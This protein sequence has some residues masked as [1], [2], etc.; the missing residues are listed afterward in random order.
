M[1]PPQAAPRSASACKQVLLAGTRIAMAFGLLCVFPLAYQMIARTGGHMSGQMAVTEIA[2]L[3][4]LS[5]VALL[6][7]TTIAVSV[8][9]IRGSR[10]F[11]GRRAWRAARPPGDDPLG[12]KRAGVDTSVW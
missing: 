7:L 12:S 10:A 11:T 4:G 2:G 3:G 5:V 1:R 6:L 8:L 9:Q